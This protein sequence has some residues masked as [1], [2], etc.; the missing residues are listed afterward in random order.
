MLKQ[1]VGE[2]VKI[3]HVL[4]KE[5]PRVGVKWGAAVYAPFPWDP[6]DPGDQGLHPKLHCGGPRSHFHV[7]PSSVYAVCLLQKINEHCCIIAFVH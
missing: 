2:G 5:P 1:T 6:E 7:L 4:F 3:A